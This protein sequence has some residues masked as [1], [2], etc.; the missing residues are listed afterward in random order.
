M[1]DSYTLLFNKPGEMAKALK[2]LT[3]EINYKNYIYELYKTPEAAIRRIENVDGLFNHRN[4]G[5][6]RFTLSSVSTL[7]LTD[8][9]MKRLKVHNHC[10]TRQ[11]VWNSGFY[12]WA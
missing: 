6:K 11:R 1:I 4:T 7:A 2:D 10:F 9:L 12:R 3:E 5:D 8:L